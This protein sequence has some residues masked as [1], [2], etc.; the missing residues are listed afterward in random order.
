MVRYFLL[1]CLLAAPVFAQNYNFTVPEFTCTVEINRDRS[2]NID[3]EIIFECTSGYSAVDIVD[4]GFPSEDFS[5]SDARAGI[6]NHELTGIY[7]STYIDNGVEVHLDQHA[8][9]GGDSGRFRFSGVNRNMVFLDTEEDDFASM[10]FTPTWFDGGVLSGH[11]D[12][13][14]NIIFPEGAEPDIVR[15][16]DVPFTS[17]KVDKDGR[18][19]YQWAERRRVD[20][21]YLVGVSFP[22]DLVDGP[23]SERPAEPWLSPEAIVLVSV[24]GFIFL[25]FSF[26]IFVVVKSVRSVSKRKEQY[27]PPKLGLEGSGI[28]R[29]LTAPMAA[30]L[31]EEKLD[32]VF[33]L[34]I[35]GLLKKGKLQLDGHKLMRIGSDQGLRSYEKELLKRIPTGGRD[36]PIPEDEIRQIFLGMIKELE[37]KMKDF[38]LKETQE[39]YRSI[40]ESAWKMVS[41]DVS[42][43]RAGEIVNNRF[44]WMLADPGYDKRVRRLSDNQNVILPVYMYG[45]FSGR[46]SHGGT[47]G[48][49]LS[50]ACSQVAGALESAAGR[51]VRNITSLSRSVTAKTN[52]VPVSTYRSSGSSGSGCACACACAGCACACAGGGR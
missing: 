14:L 42:A 15:Y 46:M 35:F 40:M 37:K 23:L 12:F 52:P 41:E 5:L 43:D 2:L 51:T 10:E 21:P 1:L 36:K 6:D 11:S 32:K 9:H 34:I 30:M 19:V 18:V 4:I 20:S 28:K 33:M 25:I 39:Y 47:G 38:S 44:H 26:I 29:G 16:H 49:S 13:T 7:Y 3:Y 48:M 8:I 24:F 22:D 50:R 31:L 17:S 45:Y 27:L